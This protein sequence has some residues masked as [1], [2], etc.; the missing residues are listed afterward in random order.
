MN[1]TSLN[2]LGDIKVQKE[3]L[4]FYF[5][6]KKL[7]TIVSYLL[8]EWIQCA[9]WTMNDRILQRKSI[10]LW[11]TIQIPQVL[12]IIRW[13]EDNDIVSGTDNC[14]HKFINNWLGTTSKNQKFKELISE[15]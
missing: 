11:L 15:Q 13:L 2:D 1:L 4:K 14:Q 6:L 9:N 3:N 7:F 10:L 12:G 5:N 8:F